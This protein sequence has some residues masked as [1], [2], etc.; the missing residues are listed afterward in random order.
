MHTDGGGTNMR[1][2]GLA[3]VT[4][5]GILGLL[6]VLVL[7]TFGLA[8]PATANLPASNFEGNDGNLVVNSPGAKDWVS[9]KG[10][11]AIGQ[12]LP[13]GATDNSLG[14]GSKDDDPTPT[15]TT[16][17]IPNNK[18]DLDRF[19]VATENVGGFPGKN[20]LYLGW[21]RN[22]TLGTANMSIE[23]NQL[24]Q[25]APPASG[26][27]P[28]QRTAGDLLILFDFASGG[29]ASDVK[30]KV[31]K[32]VTSGDPRKVCQANST[33]PCWGTATTLA[34][35]VSEGAVNLVPVTD[36]LNND[37]A[38][39][40]L[41]FGEAAINLTD[42]GLLPN[43]C[44]GFGSAMIRSRASAA[45]DSELKDF[46]APIKVSVTRSADPTNA[47]AN[48]SATGAQADATILPNPP[49]AAVT[50]RQSGAGDMT[51][52]ASQLNPKVPA[53]GSVLSADVVRATSTS[54]VGTDG[55]RQTSTAE[56]ANVNVLNGTVTADFVRGVAMTEA[57]NQSAGFAAAGSTL[58]NLKVQG[59]AVNDVAPN[60]T[61]GL[62]ALL[63]GTGSFVALD[64]LGPADGT[65]T[66]S[67]PGGV[68]QTGTFS[69]DLAVTMIH[70]HT[71]GGLFGAHDVIVSKAV[72]HSDFPG[73]LCFNRD[74]SGHAFIA[75]A[76][77]TPQVAPARIGFVA[78]PSSG[79]EQT[80][81]LD[82]VTLGDP[83]APLVTAGA[84]DSSS[85]GTITAP[86]PSSDAASFAEAG[87]ACVLAGC[88]VRAT[89]LKAASH[90]T[91][92]ASGSASDPADTTVLASVQGGAVLSQPPNT[93]QTLQGLGFVTFN[94]RIC[95]AGTSPPGCSN[96]RHSGL[97]VR[98]IHVV[99][100][101]P[102]NPLGLAAGTEIIV[103]EA[104]S[105][106]TFGQ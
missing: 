106:A 44:T 51:N 10:N 22:N 31:S 20:F 91:A 90:S 9:F 2:I 30:L 14:Q 94:E 11:V 96:G 18:S 66:T 83:L 95:D 41:T 76:T 61:I 13:S 43:L 60:T 59:A 53:D 27:W 7:G 97:T 25:P 32:W 17:G 38:L 39:P 88:V 98:G 89:V 78:I 54:H 70:V 12:D 81:H 29:K 82:S 105:D 75:S 4:C 1:R 40:Q 85:S 80:Q 103:T 99:I 55:A 84:A 57:T 104:H 37:K 34:S 36:P 21:T 47:H 26:P 3:G 52:S 24:T 71:T 79:G 35:T 68:G 15:V 23:L 16:G 46:I 64:E 33:V 58:Q 63:Y 50:T 72:A 101:V 69:A 5:R 87:N 62:P 93:T 67:Q 73:V 86:G 45:F 19:Y 6:T 8:V 102:N 100:T 28:L 92:A 42:A 49:G 77:T 48:G 56:T 65:G 74:V